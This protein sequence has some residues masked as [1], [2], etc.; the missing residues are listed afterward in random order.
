MEKNNHSL[1]IPDLTTV[2]F[3]TRKDEF[4]FLQLNFYLI[5]I[6]D[7]KLILQS[8]ISRAEKLNFLPEK[9]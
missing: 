2:E 6:I 5:Q 7:S 1:R 4:E 3:Q 8:Q 9:P